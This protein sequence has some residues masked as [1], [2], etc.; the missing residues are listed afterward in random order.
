MSRD[1][2]D[3][4]GGHPLRHPALRDCLC[5]PALDLREDYRPRATRKRL[6]LQR[7]AAA[8]EDRWIDGVND[9]VDKDSLYDQHVFVGGRCLRC[10]TDWIDASI[11]DGLDE[12]PSRDMDAPVIYTTTTGQI[13]SSSHPMD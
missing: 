13:P 7:R 8:E 6:E 2:R 12:C 10:G 9:P 4:P 5:Y 1:D 3:Q 11:Y